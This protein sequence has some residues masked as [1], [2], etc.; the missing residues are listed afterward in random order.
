MHVRVELGEECCLRLGRVLW[1]AVRLGWARWVLLRRAVLLGGRGLGGGVVL[2]RGLLGLLSGL[3]LLLLVDD[4]GLLGEQLGRRV[5]D[6]AGGRAGGEG[7]L[8]LVGALLVLAAVCG[9]EVSHG[10]RKRRVRKGREGRSLAVWLGRG[11]PDEAA[12]DMKDAMDRQI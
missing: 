8:R 6:A 3:R 2:R 12:E 11:L 9:I 1:H 5:H 7:V 4:R 10:G